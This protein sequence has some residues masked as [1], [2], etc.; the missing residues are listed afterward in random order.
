MVRN[1]LIYVLGVIFLLLISLESFAQSNSFKII[2]TGGEHFSTGARVRVARYKVEESPELVE[3]LKTEAFVNN[4]FEYTGTIDDPH[5]VAL[6]I[7]PVDSD[8]PYHRIRMALEPGETKIT[9]TSERD[10]KLIGGKLNSLIVNSWYDNPEYI[11]A[12]KSFLQ[13]LASMQKG[14]IKD[15]TIRKE[16][17]EKMKTVND[18]KEKALDEVFNS[19]NDPFEKLLIYSVGYKGTGGYEESQNK[20][21]KIALGLEDKR[22]SKLVLKS[23]KRAKESVLKQSEIGVGRVIKDFEAQYLSGETFHLADVLKKNKYVLVEFWAS[24]C[25]PC[26]EEI[27]HMKKAYSRFK[28]KGFE[29]VSF[30]LDHKKE[31]WEKASI[32]EQIPWVN[33]GDLLA[34]I[35]PVVKLYGIMGVPAN[36]LVEAATGKIISK[37]L[38]GEKL[39]QKLEELLK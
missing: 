17:Y 30:T 18:A 4:R 8:H 1:K 24:W 16:F 25:G 28:D 37:D 14:G 34:R 27:P 7:L 12:N 21:E 29:I 15:K 9:Y 38:R 20:K 19:T 26:R 32:K 11:K 2:V 36:Y 23:I 3:F 6:E 22:E 39:D 5:T 31:R 13:F 33:T 10:F 35:S